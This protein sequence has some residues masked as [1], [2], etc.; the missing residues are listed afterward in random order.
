MSVSLGMISNRE[1]DE[2]DKMRINLILDYWYDE[3]CK[4]GSGFGSGGANS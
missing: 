4:D 1:L 3:G 2:L